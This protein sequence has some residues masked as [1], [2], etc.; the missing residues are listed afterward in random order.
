MPLQRWIPPRLYQSQALNSQIIGKT[1]LEV[2]DITSRIKIRRLKRRTFLS[3]HPYSLLSYFHFSPPSS[4]QVN[5]Y[6]F[7][8]RQSCKRTSQKIEVHNNKFKLSLPEPNM[9]LINVIFH[10]MENKVWFFLLSFELC[11]LHS[12]RIENNVSKDCGQKF[13]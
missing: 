12:T 11:K 10:I 8:C 13:K 4:A 6:V 2:S 7:R 9:D 1:E 5:D 3:S